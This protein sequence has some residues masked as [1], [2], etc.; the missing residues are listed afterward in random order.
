MSV[1]L[2]EIEDRSAVVRVLCV[3]PRLF[4]RDHAS[5]TSAAEE[6]EVRL[7]PRYNLR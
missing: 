2:S 5:Q 3:S 7:P 1:K 6:A 4:M